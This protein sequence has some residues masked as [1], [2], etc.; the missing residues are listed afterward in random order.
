MGLLVLPRC[1]RSV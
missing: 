1:W